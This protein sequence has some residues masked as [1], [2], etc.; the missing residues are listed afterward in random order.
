MTYTATKHITKT[1]RSSAN[2]NV[3]DEST[4]LIIGCCTSRK[5]A[6]ALL[7]RLNND[8]ESIIQNQ[9]FSAFEAPVIVCD[10]RS[11]TVGRYLRVSTE[12]SSIQ[13]TITDTDNTGC[14]LGIDDTEKG[15]SNVNTSFEQGEICEDEIGNRPNIISCASEFSFEKTTSDSA[16][17]PIIVTSGKKIEILNLIYS[18][19]TG[20]D[21]LAT[22]TTRTIDA[23]LKLATE[24]RQLATESRQ[25]A[26]ES[27]QLATDVI[28]TATGLLHIAESALG[29]ASETVGHLSSACR[30]DFNDP[31]VLLFDEPYINV[32]STRITDSL[33]YA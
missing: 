25:L 29:I 21:L 22:E 33:S 16:T 10:E 3:I 19:K 5:S 8:V 24:S 14:V 4:G 31:L 23:A 17:E 28:S 11:Y 26:T 7:Q 18:L 30:G 20:G 9:F 12:D 2:Y 6:I 15:F 13:D 32:P 1:G 27:R